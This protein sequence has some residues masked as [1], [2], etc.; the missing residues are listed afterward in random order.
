MCLFACISVYRQKEEVRCIMRVVRVLQVRAC[1]RVTVLVFD[2]QR[3]TCSRRA[4]ATDW[5][6]GY[7]VGFLDSNMDY[8]LYVGF[9]LFFF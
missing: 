5:N 9:I 1:V 2:R 6:S 8:G 7:Y 4:V 3:L